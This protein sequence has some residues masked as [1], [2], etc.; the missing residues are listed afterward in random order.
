[1]GGVTAVYTT[2]QESEIKML[3]DWFKVRRICCSTLTTTSG[4]Q[5]TVVVSEEKESD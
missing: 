3:F 5:G 2:N 1:M 4:W